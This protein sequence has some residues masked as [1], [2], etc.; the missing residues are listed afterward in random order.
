MKNFLYNM[1]FNTISIMCAIYAAGL[2]LNGS[3]GWGWILSLSILTS[4]IPERKCGK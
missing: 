4:Y 3:G 2:T 1:M